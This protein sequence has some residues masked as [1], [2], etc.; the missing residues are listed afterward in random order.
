[1]KIYFL[2]LINWLKLK[3]VIEYICINQCDDGVGN[4]EQYTKSDSSRISKVEPRVIRPYNSLG[5]FIF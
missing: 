2:A 3:N 5:V 1:M 4:Q